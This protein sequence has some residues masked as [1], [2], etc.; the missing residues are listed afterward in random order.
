M[1]PPPH[2][3]LVRWPNRS[4]PR[5]RLAVDK[6]YNRSPKAVDRSPTFLAA[7]YRMTELQGAVALAQLEKLP[8]IVERRRRWC[9]R[10]SQ[11]LEGIVGLDLPLVTHAGTPSWWFY[12]MRVDEKALG[13]GTDEVAAALRAEGLPIGAHYIGK[14]IYEYP[15]FQEHSAFD[16]G[17]HP[18]AKRK[19]KKG[20]C[21]TA[22]A[23]LA[24][25]VMLSVNQ[26]YDDQDLEETARGIKRVVAHFQNKRA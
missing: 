2:Q 8:S 22:E 17:P 21:P 24:T 13:A 7:N 6:C 20:D 23:I 18:F 1:P 10:L 26:A 12:L 11:Q 3:R 4:H 16:H 14:T 19:Y 25:C 5:L 9:G 15:L